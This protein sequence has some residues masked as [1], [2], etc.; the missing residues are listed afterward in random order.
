MMC[1]GN[2]V[3]QGFFLPITLIA[4]MVGLA[5]TCLA[6]AHHMR[7]FRIESL[8]AAAATSLIAW[9]LVLLAVG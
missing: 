5:C 4:C 7:L 6:G 3:T 2:N 1:A 8:A 9:L